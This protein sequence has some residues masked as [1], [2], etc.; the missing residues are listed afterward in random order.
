MRTLERGFLPHEQSK[1]K[2]SPAPFILLFQK[3]RGIGITFFNALDA[4]LQKAEG[5]E[6]ELDP[7]DPADAVFDRYKP[8]R[9][10]LPIAPDGSWPCAPRDH[11][12]GWY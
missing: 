6:G 2:T 1:S 3:L 5:D 4:L 8:S 7:L 9:Y 10:V 12:H 11:P